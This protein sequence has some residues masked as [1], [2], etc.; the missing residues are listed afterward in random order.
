MIRRDLGLLF[1][2]ADDLGQALMIVSLDGTIRWQSR[3]AQKW[4]GEYFAWPRAGGSHR[5]PEPLRSWLRQ[6]RQRKDSEVAWNPPEPFVIEREVSRLVARLL[7]DGTQAV[8]VLEEKRTRTSASDLATLG[9]T[10]RE[11]E[12]LSWVAQGKTNPEIAQILGLARRTI[13]HHL[14]NIYAKLGVETRTAA[15]IRALE[16]MRESVA[17]V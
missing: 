10:P 15:A 6:T 17:H 5:L 14:E 4:I 16:V 7:S 12:V 2:G 13:H 9:L 3:R 8:I 11:A 1:R